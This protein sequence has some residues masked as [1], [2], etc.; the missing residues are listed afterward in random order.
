MQ[1]TPF[2]HRNPVPLAVAGLTVV[3]VLVV[4]VLTVGDISTGTTYSAAFAESAGLREREEVMIAGVKVGEVTR[5]DLEGDHVRVDMRIDDDVRLGSLTR[6]H[7][8]VKTL[9]GAHVVMLEPHGPGALE[10]QIP[11]SRTSVPYEIVPAAGDLA[12]SAA[13]IDPKAL[14][15]A[16]DTIGQTLEGS[17]DEIRASLSGLGRLSQSVASRDGQLHDLVRHAETVT[18]LIRGR[19]EQLRGLIKDGDL[20]LREI[21]ARR[22]VIHSLLVRTVLLSEQVEGL[23]ADNRA[24]LKPALRQ[25]RG[26]VAIL[27]RNEQSLDRS[28]RLLAPFARQFTDAIG[29]GR[30]FD[31]IIQNLVPLPASVR[32]PDMTLGGLSR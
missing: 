7:I 13:E 22:V 16:M 32:L 12:R 9:L 11:L 1:L 10:G 18:G 15:S 19:N 3:L 30:W 31:S 8:R 23:I 6:A 26:F 29:N 2:R 4:A 21:S 27:R 5:V 25:L 20:L 14:R 28:L 24:T 17:S